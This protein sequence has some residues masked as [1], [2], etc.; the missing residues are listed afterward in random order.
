MNDCTRLIKRTLA[1]HGG[2]LA[3]PMLTVAC[4]PY[5]EARLDDGLADLVVAGDVLFN[6]RGSQ[7][8]LAG[9]PLARRAL[10]ELLRG[11]ARRHVM[12]QPNKDKTLMCWGVAVRVPAADGQEDLV[13]A[14]LEMPHHHGDH[15]ERALMLRSFCALDVALG[16]Q[17][18]AQARAQAQALA[19]AQPAPAQP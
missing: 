14:E 16:Q 6:E 8:C 12:G 7:Y 13:M 3:R 11:T 17:D 2:W 1:A 19:Q 4:R 10:R 18:L 15:R 9:S 5:S